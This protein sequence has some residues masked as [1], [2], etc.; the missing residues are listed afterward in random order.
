M[1]SGPFSYRVFRETGP[2]SNFGGPRFTDFPSLCA[3]SESSLT[4]LIG[5]VFAKPFKTRMSLD[6]VRGPDFLRMTKGTPKEEVEAC[7]SLNGV[8]TL[9]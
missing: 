6:L 9:P 4:N 3:C 2:G 1:I 7:A 5:I 8:L